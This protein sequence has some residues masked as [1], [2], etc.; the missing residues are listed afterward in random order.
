MLNQ[1]RTIRPSGSGA[2]HGGSERIREPRVVAHWLSAVIAVLCP[3]FFP[4]PAQAE[5]L[6]DEKPA[7][8]Q[9]SVG[10]STAGIQLEAAYRFRPKWAVRGFIGGALTVFG[11][12]DVAGVDYEWR[13]RLGGTGLV[14]DYYPFVEGLR[15]SGGLFVPNTRLAAFSEGD[16]RIGDNEY[17]NVRLDADVEPENKVL[18][19]LSVGYVY[20]LSESLRLS[21]DVGVIYT[22]GFIAGL[23]GSAIPAIL[24]E[25][26]AK[27][28][29]QFRGQS[30]DAVPFIA[31]SLGYRF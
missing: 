2:T 15:L 20:P 3:V 28:R 27:E 7:K 26:L 25:D 1:E 22:E 23:Q 17:T 24:D 21:G 6:P 5:T 29:R 19:L 10:V 18:P 8:L 13:A 11:S 30:W 9:F 12:G 31:I 4:D 16:F 14:A